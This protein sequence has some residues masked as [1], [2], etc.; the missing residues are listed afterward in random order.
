M[1]STFKQVAIAAALAVVG[2][3]SASAAQITGSIGFSG[4]GS[5]WAF[6]GACTMVADCNGFTLFP[7]APAVNVSVDTRSGDFF[8]PVAVG[9]LGSMKAVSVAG[10]F[11][12]IDQWTLASGLFSFDLST[13]F[14]ASVTN[15]TMMNGLPARALTMFGSRTLR[16]SIAGLDPTVGIWSWSGSSTGTSFTFAPTTTAVAVPEP[17]SIAI[18][19]AGLLALAAIRRRRTS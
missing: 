1:S 8:V 18:V 19:G 14:V 10:G 12:I 9:S 6:D 16:S 2:I 7:V 3:S 11:P 13:A 15:V 5:T 17:A 4:M